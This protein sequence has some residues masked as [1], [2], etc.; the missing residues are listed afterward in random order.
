MHR[1]ISVFGHG[2]SVLRSDTRLTLRL[3]WYIP[4]IWQPHG[5][6]NPYLRSEAQT[7]GRLD[8]G[9]WGRCSSGI[10]VALPQEACA[11]CVHHRSG[12]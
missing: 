2:K 4:L 6:Q 12:I 11:F 5:H 8:A 9:L 7:R 3:P 10:R 1:S